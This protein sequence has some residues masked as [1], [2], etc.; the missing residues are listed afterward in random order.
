MQFIDGIGVACFVFNSYFN[1][2]AVWWLFPLIK[3][4]WTCK[5]YIHWEI[6]LITV[7]HIKWEDLFNEFLF[8]TC[9]L[10]YFKKVSFS[11]TN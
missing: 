8:N 7:I 5:G 11:T 10:R 4:Y 2:C 9:H 1:I 6:M 3:T